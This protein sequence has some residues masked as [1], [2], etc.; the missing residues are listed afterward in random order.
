[1][2]WPIA[3][4]TTQPTFFTLH[5]IQISPNKFNTI[6]TSSHTPLYM[7]NISQYVQIII[8]VVMC[9]RQH[10]MQISILAANKIY[11]YERFSNRTTRKKEVHSLLVCLWQYYHYAKIA[12]VVIVCWST[13]KD[14]F[15]I[16]LKRHG[17]SNTQSATD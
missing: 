1:M 7:R 5:V 9:H 12:V 2:T 4:T 3:G 10:N 13:H 11:A 6:K 14:K 17:M 16:M 8:L 15:N